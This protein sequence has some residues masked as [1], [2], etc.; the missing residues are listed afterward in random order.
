MT[1][2]VKHRGRG[3]LLG[4]ALGDALGTTLEFT[5]RDSVEPLA[6]MVGGGPF[7]L[8]PG[9]WTDDTSMALCLGYSLVAC[10]GMDSLDQL[11]RYLR[12]RDEGYCSV[13]GRCF[14]IG[15][16]V[17]AALMRFASDP[18]PYPGLTREDS[19]GNGSLMRL[20]PVALY[21]HPDK[22]PDPAQAMKAAVDSSRTTHA[23]PRCLD[24]CRV[25]AWML[26]AALAGEGRDGVFNSRALL[27]ACPDLHPE[28]QAIVAGSYRD[29]HRDDIVSTGYVAHSLEAALW[30]VW[31]SN[32]FREGALLAA[33]LGG[34]ADTITAI[35]GQLAGALVSQAGLPKD[36]L[37]VL[38][39]R[40]RIV[41][42]ADDLYY[43]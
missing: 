36:W 41:Q 21:F 11:Q 42:L 40:D 18:Q 25:Y 28:V 32:D 19:A 22:F 14:D 9:E 10:R 38:A 17:N 23:E 27:A 37:G 29:K 43:G 20:A 33:N 15:L 5:R 1:E 34:D 39:W 12:W 4:L 13:T 6:D 7:A 31:N 3:A 8:A 16:T 24:A 30:S 2:V 26:H 35:Y